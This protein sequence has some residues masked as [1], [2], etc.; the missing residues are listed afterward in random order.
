LAQYNLAICYYDG[1][2]VP[3]DYVNAYMWLVIAR[4]NGITEAADSIRIVSRKMSLK[5]IREAKARVKKYL[6][7]HPQQ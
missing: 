4:S 1:L 5:Q 3:V 6:L 2:S 7:A